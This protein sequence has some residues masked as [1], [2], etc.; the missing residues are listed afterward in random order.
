[1][2][3]VDPAADRRQLAEKFGAEGV[4]VAAAVERARAAT[5][6]RGVDAVVEAVGS[7]AATALAYELVRPGG[8]IAAVGVH[9]EAALAIPPGKLY[10]KNLTYRAGRCPARAYLERALALLAAG[11]FPFAALVS[12]RLALAEAPASYAAFDRRE[13]GWTKV[14]FGP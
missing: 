12:H 11:R 5:A 1:V 7:P 9:H 14:V 2:F 3:A 13:P 10:D 6:G 4:D 8:T